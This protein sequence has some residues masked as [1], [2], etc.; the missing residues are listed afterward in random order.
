MPNAGQELW[1]M[2]A[3]YVQLLAPLQRFGM[4][5]TTMTPSRPT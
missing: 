4:P 5:D 1:A 2:A 3:Q